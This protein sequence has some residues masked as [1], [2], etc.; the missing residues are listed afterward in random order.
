MEEIKPSMTEIERKAIKAVLETIIENA[1]GISSI[2]GPYVMFN[3]YG[4]PHAIPLGDQNLKKILER[5][6]EEA[7]IR[8]GDYDKYEPRGIIEAEARAKRT[9]ELMCT[10]R[11]SSINL[12]KK[13][14][15]A[16]V[17]VAAL[18]EADELFA[19]RSSEAMISIGSLFENMSKVRTAVKAF[20]E[21]D[22]NEKNTHKG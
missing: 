1:I 14:N 15:E 13:V 12:G 4:Q 6:E 17:L 8:F 19:G 3:P 11:E 20:E 21:V 5:I 18:K 10:Y 9:Y 22:N 2:P 16:R 7:L